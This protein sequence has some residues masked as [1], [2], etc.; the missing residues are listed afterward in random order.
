MSCSADLLPSAPL[1]LT[2][3]MESVQKT[4]CGKEC[5]YEHVPWLTCYAGP[6]MVYR[7]WLDLE[8]GMLGRDLVHNLSREEWLDLEGI[9][10]YIL[11]WFCK[12]IGS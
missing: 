5:S 1:S 12:R 8:T 6:E 4:G 11:K 9:C 10:C 2:L 3:V 7:T